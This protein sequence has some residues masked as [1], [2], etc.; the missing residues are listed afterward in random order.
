MRKTLALLAFLA[1]VGLTPALGLFTEPS[2]TYACSCVTPGSP[3]EELEASV[4]VF[5]GEVVSVEEQ[6]SLLGLISSTD[7]TT[8]EFRVH[9]VWKGQVGESISLVT[10]RLGA[11][12]GFTFS[13]GKRYVVYS[14]D[15]STVSLCSRTTPSAQAE[16]DLAVLGDGKT[17]EAGS[18]SPK[19]RGGCGLAPVT[20]NGVVDVPLLG[21]AAGLLWLGWRRWRHRPSR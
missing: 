2:P 5:A 14:R 6:R 12:C 18:V 17:P 1:L 9:T 15:E 10:A 11:S 3:S 16:E 7:P 8:V 19:P 20:G 13:T 4:L 21:L